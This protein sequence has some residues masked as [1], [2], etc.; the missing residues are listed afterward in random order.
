MT[1][2]DKY[3][4]ILPKSIWKKK[5]NKIRGVPLIRVFFPY[6]SFPYLWKNLDLVFHISAVDQICFFL[7]FNLKDLQGELNVKVK[8]KKEK[9]PPTQLTSKGD[10]QPKMKSHL[11]NSAEKNHEIPKK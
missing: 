7:I 6:G 5:K 10:V 9:A 8:V 11:K 1:S 4:K 3:G 2:Y